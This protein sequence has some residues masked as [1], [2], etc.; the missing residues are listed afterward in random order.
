MFRSIIGWFDHLFSA[1]TDGWFSFGF[2][3]THFYPSD[4]PYISSR[5]SSLREPDKDLLVSIWRKVAIEAP[6]NPEEA[7]ELIDI[8]LF[9][10]MNSDNEPELTNAFRTFKDS[11][12]WEELVGPT[13]AEIFSR[14]DLVH[15]DDNEAETSIEEMSRHINEAE[16]GSNH[17]S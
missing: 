8:I 4:L 13:E 15:H 17:T 1:L 7:G 2:G 5:I 6:L 14:P 10:E 11:G 3:R 16:H 12:E 9:Y